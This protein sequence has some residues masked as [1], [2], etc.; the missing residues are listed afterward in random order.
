MVS[1]S[2]AL[3]DSCSNSRTLTELPLD[4]S[5]VPSPAW[6]K[7]WIPTLVQAVIA[8]ATG[9]SAKANQVV[10]AS[11]ETSGASTPTLSKSKKRKNAAAGRK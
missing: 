3:H 5:A 11:A 6:S 4:D 7:T 9:Q 1:R 10:E 2:A 8:K